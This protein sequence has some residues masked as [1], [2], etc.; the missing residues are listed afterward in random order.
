MVLGLGNPG[1]AYADTRHNVGFRIVEDLAARH[2]LE[3]SQRRWSSRMAIGQLSGHDTALVLPQTYMN[4]SGQAL[5]EALEDWPGLDLSRDL[6]VVYDDLD[7]PCGQIRLRS[8]GGSG[9]HR[10]MESLIETVGSGDFPRLRFGVGRP[11]PEGRDAVD[12]VL[13]PFGEA[14]LAHLP[15]RIDCASLALEYF[16]EAGMTA[17]MDRFNSAEH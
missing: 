3:L 2:G 10:G 7:L 13:E 11:E 9:G 5:A 14:D 8:S 4:R 1:D 17:A 15:E 6:V 16:L 12:F